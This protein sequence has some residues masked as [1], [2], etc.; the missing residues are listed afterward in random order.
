MDHDEDPL[1]LFFPDEP[2][3]DLYNVLGLRSDDQP[4]E[5]TIRKAYR[6]LALRYHPDKVAQHGH[7]GSS[8]AAQK[9]QQIGFA[10]SV[11]S[12]EKR[13][14]KY[15]A[16]GST[17]D[18]I[19]DSDEPIDWNEYFATLWSGEVSAKTLNEFKQSYQ[20][21]EEERKDV[22]NAYREGK[23]HLDHIFA[24]VPCTN[25]LEDETRIIALV[26]EALVSEELPKTK[27]WMAL[28]GS[29]GAKKRD[30]LRKQARKEAAE[31]E[32]YAKELGV[33]DTLYGTATKETVKGKKN[34]TSAEKPKKHKGESHED[35]DVDLEALRRA[36]QAKSNERASKFD[37]MMARLEQ[38]HA[39]APARP[40]KR[41]AT[42]RE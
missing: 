36:M 32:A 42:Q 12:D 6:R 35:D 22:L 28:K 24:T 30:R 1:R 37:E 4:D 13:R 3:V 9:F 27:A 2:D 26:D 38:Q 5:D 33:W 29:D 41:R 20:N 7:D 34:K 10:Y 31:A 18:S 19:W 39:P 11:L 23:G 21:S 25:F 16:T 40:K 15:D 14:K 8:A 17:K